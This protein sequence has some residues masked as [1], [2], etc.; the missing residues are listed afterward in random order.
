[1]ESA[2]LLKP[3]ENEQLL[4]TMIQLGQEIRRQRKEEEYYKN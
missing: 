3:I 2:Y 4:D 1:M